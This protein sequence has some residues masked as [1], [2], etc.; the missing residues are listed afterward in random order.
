MMICDEINKKTYLC[1]K[2]KF[3]MYQ[4]QY[5]DGLVVSMSTSH[6]VGRGF[7]SRPGHTKDRHKNGTNCLPTWQ[8]GFREEFGRGAQL[9]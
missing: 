9:F 6:A 3:F 8:A 1:T 5:W 7:T 2:F 4:R